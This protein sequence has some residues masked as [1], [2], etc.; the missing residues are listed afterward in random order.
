M[1]KIIGKLTLEKNMLCWS[2]EEKKVSKL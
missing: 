1:T 2:A